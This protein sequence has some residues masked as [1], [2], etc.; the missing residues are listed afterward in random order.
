M[1][2][3]A[4]LYDA[5]GLLKAAIR[6]PDPVIYLEHKEAYRAVR[7]K[8]PAGDYALAI[9]VAEWR[10]RGDGLTVMSY[11]MMLYEC[12]AAAEQLAGEGIEAGVLDLG[13]LAPLDRDAIL[14]AARA[15]G[16]VLMVHEENLSGGLGAEVAALIA[17]HAFGDLDAPVRRLAAPDMPL[18]LF[19]ATLEEHWLPSR[20][21]I[22]AALRELAAY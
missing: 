16:K 15:T 8:V 3:P 22:A 7:G 4:T 12:L 1:V 2:A 11:G 18:M 6:D 9:G 14:D 13:M 19:N 5:K 20:Q 21:T 17:E 10:R